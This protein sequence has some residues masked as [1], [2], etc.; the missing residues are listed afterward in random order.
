MCGTQ[1][2]FFWCLVAATAFLLATV[3]GGIRVA[4]GEYRVLPRPHTPEGIK[5]QSETQARD[6]YHM[7]GIRGPLIVYFKKNEGGK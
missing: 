7:I 1:E 4:P 6:G 5:G 3:S 2:I